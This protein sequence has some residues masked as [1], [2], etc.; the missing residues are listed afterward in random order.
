MIVYRIVRVQPNGT[1]RVIK[2]IP[3]AGG[4]TEEQQVR[5]QAFLDG[6][7]S[8]QSSLHI[9]VYSSQDDGTF[10]AGDVIW[11]SELYL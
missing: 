4:L 3:V 2:D 1:E 5:A 8:A 10:S 11:D 7:A 9:R 6:R